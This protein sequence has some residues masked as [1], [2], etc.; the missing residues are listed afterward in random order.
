M[1]TTRV[2]ARHRRDPLLQAGVLVMLALV[3]S[4]CA[5]VTVTSY[6]DPV[7]GA[8]P[9]RTFNWQAMPDVTTGDPRLDNNRFFRE[10]VESAIEQQLAA[11]GFRKSDAP[12]LAIHYH[13]RLEQA[14][15]VSRLENRSTA[16]QNGDPQLYDAG[17]LLIDVVDRTGR[18]LWRGYAHASVD[19]TDVDNQPLMTRRIEEAVRRILATFPRAG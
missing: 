16:Y 8:R 17:T 6:L 19:V 14:F 15:Y 3:S 7:V 2:E 18:L 13:V 10:S 9:Y 1:D 11:R 12:D 5:V 4:S